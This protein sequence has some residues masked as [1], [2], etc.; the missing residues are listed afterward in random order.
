M[1]LGHGT[2]V[3]VIDT[4]TD[5]EIFISDSF[6]TP[7]LVNSQ[8]EAYWGDAVIECVGV[9]GDMLVIFTREGR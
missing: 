9:Y 4:A 6:I 3:C 8:Y 7:Y 5:D 1:L 2:K